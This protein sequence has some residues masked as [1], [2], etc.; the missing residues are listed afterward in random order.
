MKK[1]AACF[2]VLTAGAAMLQSCVITTPPIE[3]SRPDLHQYHF[4]VKDVSEKP[5]QGVSATSTLYDRGERKKD[6]ILTTGE[7]GKTTFNIWANADTTDAYQNLYETKCDY[8][9]FKAG[10]LPEYGTLKISYLLT[11][12]S[13]RGHKGR[14]ENS[15]TVTLYQMKD[16]ISNSANTIADTAE[17]NAILRYAEN[18]HRSFNSRGITVLPHSV[19]IVAQ[20]GKRYLSATMNTPNI[21]NIDKLDSA[22]MAKTFFELAGREAF[23]LLRND[24]QRMNDINGFSLTLTG[25]KKHFN[26]PSDSQEPVECRLSINKEIFTSTES[27]DQNGKFLSGVRAFIDGKEVSLSE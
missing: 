20:A 6:E 13:A 10:Y 5:I 17:R 16:L 3:H 21:M 14:D 18:L 7:D 15:I 1:R 22:G 23:E 24:S 4:T 8:T 12:L 2:V 25:T 26:T 9:I 27:S 19:D 11:D